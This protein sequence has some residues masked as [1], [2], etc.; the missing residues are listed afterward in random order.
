[1]NNV[2]TLDEVGNVEERFLFTTLIY[3]GSDPE[4]LYDYYIDRVT[5]EWVKTF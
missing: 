4:S 1:M 2:I 3:T 5:H